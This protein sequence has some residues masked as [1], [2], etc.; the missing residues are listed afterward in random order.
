[1]KN[2]PAQ[3]MGSPSLLAWIRRRGLPLTKASYIV[4]MHM[5]QPV[6]FPLD[7]EIIAA[8]PKDLPGRVPGSEVDLY[9]R[10]TR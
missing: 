3:P 4:A 2:S 5:G 10:V 1:M 7:A 6:T 8:I 9:R